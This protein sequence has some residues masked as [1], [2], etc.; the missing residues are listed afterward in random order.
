MT[1]QTP[2]QYDGE[3]GSYVLDPATGKRT[4]VERT[5][6]PADAPEEQTP[7]ANADQE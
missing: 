5:F 2:D 3:G 7:A 6:D 4:L 1:E